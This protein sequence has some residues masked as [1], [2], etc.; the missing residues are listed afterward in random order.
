[1]EYTL[2][3]IK[4]FHATYNLAS[5]PFAPCFFDMDTNYITLVYYFAPYYDNL[6]IICPF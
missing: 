5:F 3:V 4:V 1:L 2:T 6:L